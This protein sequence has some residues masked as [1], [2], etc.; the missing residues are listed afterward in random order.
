MDSYNDDQIGN[1]YEHYYYVDN[2]QKKL[3]Y[4]VLNAYHRENGSSTV[5]SGYTSEQINWFE[6]DALQ[7]ESGWDILVF[8]HYIGTTYTTDVNA[9]AIRDLIDAYNGDPNS[10]GHIIAIIQ[11]HT[12]FDTVCHTTG[13]VPIITTTCDKNV[14]WISGGV[15]QEE[16]LTEYR[17][18]N[19]I[20]EQAF[21]IMILDRESKQIKAVRIGSPA[22]DNTDKNYTDEG[23]DFSGTL[24]ERTISYS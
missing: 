6:G 18:S 11:G 22:M 21:D 5:S 19:T 15:N 3:R 20:N 12:H 4:V 13:G 2:H 9:Q 24:E 16:W 23:F 7:V 8:T 1:M 17:A 10:P 14:G